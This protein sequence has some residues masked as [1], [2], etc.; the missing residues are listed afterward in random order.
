VATAEY[1]RSYLDRPWWRARRAKDQYV[2]Q[3]VAVKGADEAF[4]LAATLDDHARA[5]GAVYSAD[6]RRQDL[7][8]AIRMRRLLDRAGR[9]SRRPR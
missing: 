7:E 1:L 2:A 4:R 5:M 6:E 9:R 3:L 8:A